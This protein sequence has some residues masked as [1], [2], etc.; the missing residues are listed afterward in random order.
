MEELIRRQPILEKI[1]IFGSR[2][3]GTGSTR[4]DCD[5]LIEF[6]QAQNL[7]TSDLRDF[8]LEKCPALDFFVAIGG[9]AT[10]C[11]N[12]SYVYAGSVEELK[13]RLD[14][15][16][17]WSRADGFANSPFDA[18][19][20]VFETNQFSDY[21]PTS[22]P[23]A[24]ISERSW[25][26][27]IKRAEQNNL[28]T[29]PYIGDSVDLASAILADVA[30]KMILNKADLCQRGKAVDGWTVA[31]NSEYDCQ[32]LFYTVIKPW[33]GSV[34]R[35]EVTISYDGQDKKADFHL[36]GNRLIIEMKFIESNKKKQEVIK[37]LDGLSKFY[38]T[39][40][41]IR[42]LLMLIFVKTL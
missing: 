5:L 13:T 19:S 39:N 22:L 29:L 7:K 4:S 3:Y 33:I 35:E 38:K 17:I 18:V 15:K 23:D 36:F 37:T 40:A 11:S 21:I 32:N 2:A 31:L 41:N 12:D 27:I 8:T 16:L 6:D 28:P 42:I 1:S 20:W 34:G 14:A 10:S 24:H 25:Q 9:R 30:K 26:A